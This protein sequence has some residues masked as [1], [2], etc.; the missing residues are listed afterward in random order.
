MKKPNKPV[1]PKRGEIWRVNFGPSEGKEIRKARPAIVIG[2]DHTRE[3]RMTIV[4]PLTGW[5]PQYEKLP[6]MVA[7]PPDRKNNLDKRDAANVLQIR[8][9]SYSRFTRK[10]GV[11][12]ARQV[13]DI[14]NAV[15]LCIGHE[16]KSTDN[17][18]TP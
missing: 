9:A 15:M 2:L 10:I 3:L 5:K 13:E 7:I 1:D 18:F 12:A 11:V 14:I 16:C 6:W 8:A 17:S 4:V